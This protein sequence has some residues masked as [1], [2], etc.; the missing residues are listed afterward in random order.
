M[1]RI[2][3]PW[4]ACVSIVIT[5]GMP[6]QLVE[7]SSD[8]YQKCLGRCDVFAE[9]KCDLSCTVHAFG[10][11]INDCLS[12]ARGR[13]CGK[14]KRESD[15]NCKDL[16]DGQPSTEKPY[17]EPWTD[18]YERCLGKCEAEGKEGNLCIITCTLP[19]FRN[20]N[21]RLSHVECKSMAK[22]RACDVCDT[23]RSKTCKDLC[24]E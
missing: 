13:A 1:V 14:C 19:A 18:G 12:T 23:E 21:A 5:V 6:M 2:R 22:Q 20:C 9:G 15:R 7:P 8:G 10:Q 4:L 16:C 11:C 17:V 24:I 3:N